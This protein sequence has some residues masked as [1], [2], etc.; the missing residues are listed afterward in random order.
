M[1]TYLSI[2]R[3]SPASRADRIGYTHLKNRKDN[4]PECCMASYWVQHGVLPFTPNH[5]QGQSQRASVCS[6]LL[7]RFRMG[8]TSADLGRVSDE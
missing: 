7:L 1:E 5:S 6:G 3:A 4:S 8:N 2:A